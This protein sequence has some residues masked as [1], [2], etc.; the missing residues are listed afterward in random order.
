MSTHE[1]V[2][3]GNTPQGPQARPRRWFWVGLLLVGVLLGSV[4]GGLFAGSAGGYPSWGCR[5]RDAHSIE[6]VRER[7][8]FMT[9][10]LLRRIEASEEQRQQIQSIVQKAVTD[11][12][13]VTEAHRKNRQAWR[14]ALTQPT[15]DRQALEAL[16]QAEVQLIDTAS[17]QLVG[18]T[19]EVAQVLTPGQRTKLLERVARFH[20]TPEREGLD[21]QEPEEP[22]TK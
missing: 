5:W 1:S 8:E 22:A 16:R 18:A 4:L 13:P 2:T 21:K 3:S 14:E 9:D 19:V 17:N 15:V 7:A 6:A 11:L 20:P 12:A 10:W